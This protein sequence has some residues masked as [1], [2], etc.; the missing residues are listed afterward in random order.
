MKLAVGLGGSYDARHRGHIMSGRIQG[1][2]RS[3]SLFLIAGAF[4]ALQHASRGQDPTSRPASLRGETAGS[5]ISIAM[6]PCK[7]T[8]PGEFTEETGLISLLVSGPPKDKLMKKGAI[9]VDGESFAIYLPKKKKGYTTKNTGRDD[10]HNANTSTLLSI[11]SNHDGTLT[12]DESW[13]ANLPVRIGDR[14]F[15][16]LLIEPDGSRIDVRPSAAPLR[17]MVVGRKC[18]QFELQIDGGRRVT[19]E[20]YAGKAFLLDIWSVT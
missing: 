17:G 12:R 18:P 15:D 13:N 5:M 8:R 7:A 6:E 1:W 19:P 9:D 10:S 14:M 2:L 11:D 3:V 20:S 16:V 4:F